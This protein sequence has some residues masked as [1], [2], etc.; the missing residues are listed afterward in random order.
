MKEVVGDENRSGGGEVGVVKIPVMVFGSGV[1]ATVE[2][3]RGVDCG[4]LGIVI[5]R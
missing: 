2:R 1:I 3:K 5:G 4:Y